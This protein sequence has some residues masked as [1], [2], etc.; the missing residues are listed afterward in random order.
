M[1]LSAAEPLKPLYTPDSKKP[2]A[3]GITRGS[4]VAGVWSAHEAGYCPV[5]SAAR[6]LRAFKRFSVARYFGSVPL[7]E[8]KTGQLVGSACA[9]MVGNLP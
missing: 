6:P 2:R 5:S 9:G 7:R 3:K 8:S 4:Y 1:G